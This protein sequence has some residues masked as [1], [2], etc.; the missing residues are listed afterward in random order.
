MNWFKR[1]YVTSSSWENEQH[2]NIDDVTEV[3]KVEEISEYASVSGDT[4][5]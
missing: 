3:I 1:M 4:D 5:R 2:I